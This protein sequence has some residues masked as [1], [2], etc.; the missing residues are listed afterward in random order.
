MTSAGTWGSSMHL[1]RWSALV[2]AI[3]SVCS[4][5]MASDSPLLRREVVVVVRTGGVAS[6][7]FTLTSRRIGKYTTPLSFEVIDEKNRLL[8]RGLWSERG[9]TGFPDRGGTPMSP[10]ERLKTKDAKKGTSAKNCSVTS[11]SSALKP[12]P[13]RST[14]VFDARAGVLDSK[15]GLLLR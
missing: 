6:P 13:N 5:S 2:F 4:A 11:P 12:Q 10:T 9:G 1:T 3:T 7:A 15:L 14:S 8:K